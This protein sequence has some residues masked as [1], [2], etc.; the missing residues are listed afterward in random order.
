MKKQPASHQERYGYLWLA[1]GLI[2]SLFATNG[3]WDIP[4]A[5]WL[6]PLF[7]LRFTRISRPF[8]G[9]CGI[10]LSSIVAMFFFFYQSQ[11]LNPLITIACL[12][13]STVLSLPYLLDRLLAP[14]ISVASGLLTTL[15]FPLGR[16]VCE[17]LVSST[18]FGSLFSLAYTQY[19]NLPLLQL[20]SITGIYGVSFLMA[21]FASVGNGI[22]EQHFAWPR[23]R[24]AALLY[25]TLL[26]LTLIGGS[27]RLAFF[28]PLA[29]TVRV[30]GISVGTTTR[31]TLLQQRR[32]FT[33]KEQLT[34]ADLSPLRAAFALNNED[35]FTRSQREARA[36]AK[37]I[38][39]PEA[40][41]LTM[42]E[43]EAKLVERGKTLARQEQI[44][45]EMGLVVVQYK[46]SSLPALHDR[47]ILLDPQGNVVWTYDK[48]H[49]IP[50]MESFAAGDGVVPTV[51]TPYGRLANVICF[52]GDFLDL[53]R[54]GGSKQVDMMLVP[55]N[56]W[57]GID[58]MHTQH[59]AFRAIENGYSLVRQTSNGLALT[60]DYQGHILAASDYFTTNEQTMI[61]FV[62]K[63]GVTTIYALVG[64][65]F[66]W[67]C[68][69]S[70]LSLT[71]FVILR[72]IQSRRKVSAPATT[73]TNAGDKV[74]TGI[75]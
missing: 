58:P 62:P 26:A 17:Y 25:G 50:G 53:M 44:Y 41:A 74:E 71:G 35:L 51:D 15:I 12:F 75:L 10:W 65:L 67:L 20:L 40:A 4:I 36:G 8:I 3:R 47:S 31:Q 16:V 52:D 42:V 55:S 14:R 9:F 28:P 46:A 69:A 66:A 45:L 18:P 48:A 32:N 11:L 64:D 73:P 1:L 23:I 63:K 29:Q 60:V 49:P 72:S 13:F 59:I 7:F 56:D 27:I 19:D 39:W 54:Q 38:V 33:T 24:K 5:A 34:N 37:I 21:W 70:L 6:Y 30:A 2:L 61:A 43:D 57:Q 68:I 22:W